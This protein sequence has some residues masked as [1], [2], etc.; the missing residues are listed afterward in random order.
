MEELLRSAIR[1]DVAPNRF[2]FA[3]LRA[4]THR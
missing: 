1:T 3:D 2:I 4:A